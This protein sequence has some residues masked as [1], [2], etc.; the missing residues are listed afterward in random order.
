MV[1]SWSDERHYEQLGAR[2]AAPHEFP[3]T[4]R[5][6]L[7]AKDIERNTPAYGRLREFYQSDLQAYRERLNKEGD[8]L[9]FRGEAAVLQPNLEGVLKAVK[10]LRP[11]QKTIR[12]ANMNGKH[13]IPWFEGVLLR[14]EDKQL[15]ASVLTVTDEDGVAWVTSVV[16]CGCRA[17][18]SFRVLVPFEV[19]RSTVKLLDK[20][21]IDLRYRWLVNTLEL[22]Q[23]ERGDG[24]YDT[25]VR[26]KGIDLDSV[27]MGERLKYL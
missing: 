4:S 26:I 19:L 12:A 22:R 27:P 11:L 6:E 24:R 25:Q 17:D 7:L 20:A 23:G 15:S 2:Y 1:L 13:Y 14:F 10:K 21:R 5:L 8:P 3:Y 9:A 18:V 16:T